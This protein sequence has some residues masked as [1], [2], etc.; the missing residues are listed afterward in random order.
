MGS[1]VRRLADPN[2]TSGFVIYSAPILSQR[3]HAAN[4]WQ[5][6]LPAGYLAGSEQAKGEVQQVAQLEAKS[7]RNRREKLYSR[8]LGRAILLSKN[9]PSLD[10][11][12]LPPT[13]H[14][15]LSRSLG[16]AG[17]GNEGRARPR[18]AGQ[19]S[20]LLTLVHIMCY[21]L[22]QFQG[23][24]ARWGNSEKTRGVSG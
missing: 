2:P 21:R 7:P 16:G 11:P 3:E 20:Y 6:E 18:D 9:G 10:V 12:F 5:V 17:L 23:A 19:D 22:S 24:P 8:A 4:S 14:F 13:K 1:L 15:P